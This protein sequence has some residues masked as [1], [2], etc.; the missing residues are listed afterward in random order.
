MVCAS[1][2]GS[3]IIW[4]YINDKFAKVPGHKADNTIAA[5]K[6]HNQFLLSSDN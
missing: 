5:L 2:E 3:F 1:E 6:A 4:D